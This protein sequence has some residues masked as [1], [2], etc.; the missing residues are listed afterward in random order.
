MTL[1]GMSEDLV[2]G[3]NLPPWLRRRWIECLISALN[4]EIVCLRCLIVV[5]RDSSN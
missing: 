5:P 1:L 3:C 2:W 4:L